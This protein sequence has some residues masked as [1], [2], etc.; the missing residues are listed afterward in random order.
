[1]G[2][3]FFD[4]SQALTI[5]NEWFLLSE[6][7]FNGGLV[8]DLSQD[9][10]RVVLLLKNETA[11]SLRLID[12]ST[13]EDQVIPLDSAITHMDCYGDTIAYSKRLNMQLFHLMHRY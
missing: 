3:N 4:L 5:S 13:N 6:F 8:T 2:H 7:T 11:E 10:E 9:G 12:L 1:M